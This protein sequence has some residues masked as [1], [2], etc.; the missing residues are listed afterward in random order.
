MVKHSIGMHKKRQ[1]GRKIR[2]TV[3]VAT[4]DAC[5]MPPFESRR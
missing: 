2:R 4:S 3:V 5:V 1:P